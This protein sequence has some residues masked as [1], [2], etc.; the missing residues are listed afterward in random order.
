M[1]LIVPVYKC[2]FVNVITHTNRSV[3][4]NLFVIDAQSKE[5]ENGFEAKYAKS[6]T[7]SKLHEVQICVT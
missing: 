2:R 5:R 4:T 7:S 6:D 3:L 1:E